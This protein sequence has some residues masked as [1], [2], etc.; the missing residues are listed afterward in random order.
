MKHILITAV[1]IAGG[2]VANA[3]SNGAVTGSGQTTSN[4]SATAGKGTK[5]KVAKHH[6]PHDYTPGSPIGTGGAGDNMSGSRNNSALKTAL[7]KQHADSAQQKQ[8]A[9]AKSNP[10]KKPGS[11]G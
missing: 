3:Q 8:Q 11:K 1:F 6:G 9:P 7:Q 5:P 4:T 10:G 2:F